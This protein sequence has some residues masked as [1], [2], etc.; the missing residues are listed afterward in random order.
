M[1]GGFATLRPPAGRQS[2]LSAYGCAAARPP[3]YAPPPAPVA[4]AALLSGCVYRPL[5]HAYDCGG[6]WLAPAYGANGVY[7]NAVPPP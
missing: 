7:Y 1:V 5:P 6:T 3:A 4:Y 2:C